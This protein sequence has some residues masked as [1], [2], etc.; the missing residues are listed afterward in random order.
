MVRDG[1]PCRVVVT[2]G[3]APQCGQSFRGVGCISRTISFFHSLQP[4]SHTKMS[5]DCLNWGTWKPPNRN[6]NEKMKVILMKYG[7]KKNYSHIQFYASSTATWGKL[8]R[9]I[10]QKNISLALPAPSTSS[11]IEHATPG[12][13]WCKVTIT[14][15]AN[16]LPPQTEGGANADPYG[17]S[18]SPSYGHWRVHQIPTLLVKKFLH[19]PRFSTFACYSLYIY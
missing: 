9:N 7:A 4:P 12:W 5:A 8:Y 18:P 15:K 14:I 17:I 11:A 6:E 2:G 16:A 19:I 13:Q 1:S 3:G 10:L